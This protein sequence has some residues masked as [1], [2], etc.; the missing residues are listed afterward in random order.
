MSQDHSFIKLGDEKE[1]WHER[2]SH[3]S[4]VVLTELTGT[5]NGDMAGS[6]VS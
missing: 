1:N 4:F 6:N 2:D 3:G 5:L